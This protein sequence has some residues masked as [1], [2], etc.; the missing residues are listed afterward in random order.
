MANYQNFIA[1]IEQA[2]GGYQNNPIDALGNTNS[3]GQLVGTNR[4]INAKVY[5]K[6]IGR[7]PSIADMKAITRQ[8]ALAIFKNNYWDRMKADQIQSQA[9]AETLVDHAIN[10]S[11]IYAPKMIQR[12]VGVNDDGKIGNITLNAIN[13]YPEKELFIAF[14]NSRYAYY[15]NIKN[16][17]PTLYHEFIRGWKKRV[18][19][20]YN[21][22]IAFLTNAI[23]YTTDNPIKTT[24]TGALTL[25]GVAFLIYKILK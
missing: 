19:D 1:S 16:F 8:T 9:I 12:I 25:S 3:L 10:A 15:E 21:K 22:H 13:Q 23:A 4:G 2:E 11:P 5:E 18:S 7:P 17:K 20:M 14:T 24:A 6:Y